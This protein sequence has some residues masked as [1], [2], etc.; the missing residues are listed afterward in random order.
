MKKVKVLGSG[1]RNCQTTARMIEEVASKLGVPVQ[2]EKVEDISEI[3]QHGVMSTPGVIVNN[4]VVH[5]GGLPSMA[6]IEKWLS[7]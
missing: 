6:D 1:C 4:S 5:A 3:M 2:I 7:Q